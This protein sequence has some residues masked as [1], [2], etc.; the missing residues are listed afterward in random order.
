V[1]MQLPFLRRRGG[2]AASVAIALLVATAPC[3]AQDAPLFGGFYG[4]LGVGVV[5]L[6]DSHLDYSGAIANYR[7]EYDAGW[8]VSG[9]LGFRLR[10]HWRLEVEISHRENDVFDVDPGV[11][12]DGTVTSTTYMVN[13]YYDFPVYSLSGFVP[14][15]GA[16]LGRAQFTHDIDLNG[17]RLSDAS[18]HALAYQVIGGLEFPVISR[19]MSATLEYRYLATTRP[20]FQDMGGFFYHTDYDSHSIVLGLRWAF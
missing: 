1:E 4:A 7:V 8:A 14:Y 12:A 20:L 13:S 15:I 2:L 6:E 17:G 9:A 3:R 5:G 18:S 19:K 10:R 16:G 11:D